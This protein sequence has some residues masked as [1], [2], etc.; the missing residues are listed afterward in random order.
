MADD[1]PRAAFD[2]W[3]LLAAIVLPALILVAVQLRGAD[4]P[5]AAKLD[6][7]ELHAMAA[8][9]QPRTITVALTGEILPHP[10][11]V[12]HARRFGAASGRP[13]DFAPMFADVRRLVRR[14]D[15]AICH[16]E[17]PVA[18]PGTPLSGYPVFAIPPEVA[19]GIRATG[20]DRCSTASN[21]SNDQGTAGIRATIDALAGAGVG[22]SGTAR[23]RKEA[24]APSIVDVDG[25]RVAH[26]AATA[27]FNGIPPDEPW[28]ADLIDLHRILADARRAREAGADLVIVSL[29]WGIE[30]DSAGDVHQRRLAKTLLD[31][32]DVDLIVGHGPHVLQPIERFHRKYALLSVGN[33]VANQGRERPS[34]YDGVVATVT[35]TQ[36]PDGRFRAA[37]PVVEPTWYD[38][39]TGHVWRVRTALK[40][41]SAAP[42]RPELRASLQRTRAV[43]GPYVPRR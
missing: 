41:P 7:V 8:P 20:W 9:V 43:L 42:L 2:H 34:T 18:P 14:A 3:R 21:H 29:H 28:M 16:L 22:H 35:F 25:I 36:R 40:D 33:L 26:L 19:D 4:H 11:V 32:R 17:V 31:S 12:E 23:T 37:P 24:A 15:L 5:T 10:S 6:D 39:T 27:G 38:G 30:Y 1:R 13:F